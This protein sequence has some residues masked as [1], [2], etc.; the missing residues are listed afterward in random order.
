MSSAKRPFCLGLTVLKLTL[1]P[2]D[3]NG[4]NHEDQGRGYVKMMYL[5]NFLST[6][7]TKASAGMDVN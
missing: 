5:Q 7:G 3:Q 6:Q 1:T 2:L 4:V